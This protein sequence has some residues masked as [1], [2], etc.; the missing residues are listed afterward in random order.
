MWVKVYNESISEWVPNTPILQDTGLI[1]SY[2]PHPYRDSF[3]VLVYVFHD[4]THLAS[5]SVTICSIIACRTDNQRDC[6]KLHS[7]QTWYVPSPQVLSLSVRNKSIIPSQR[8]SSTAQV[9]YTWMDA[10]HAF[11]GGSGGI[12]P[13]NVLKSS[14]F[15][16][17]Y[18]KPDTHEANIIL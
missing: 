7:W 6:T 2:L 9:R 8:D 5:L 15:L 10:R 17:G 12:L 4:T 11:I 18:L 1:C 3:N 14:C 16:M 13:E